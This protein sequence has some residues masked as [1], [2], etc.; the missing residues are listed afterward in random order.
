MIYGRNRKVSN[1]SMTM[2]DKLENRQSSPPLFLTKESKMN[3]LNAIG[4]IG[5][6]CEIRYTPSGHAV[7]NFTLALTSGYG[8][9]AVTSWLNCQLWGERAEKLTNMLTKGTRIGVTGELTNRPYTS[10][11][12]AQKY[13]LELRVSDVTLLGQRTQEADAP[14][15]RE[16]RQSGVADVPDEFD[17][18]IP[19]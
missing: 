8:E 19:F 2:Q 4:N 5:K 17:E 6:D 15:T 13:S 11:D 14:Q 9:K 7:A 3:Q 12:G 18:D 10:K 1:L 16:P